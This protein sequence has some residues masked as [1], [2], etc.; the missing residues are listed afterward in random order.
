MHFHDMFL[1]SRLRCG[2]AW[3][4]ELMGLRVGFTAVRPPSVLIMTVLKG[5]CGVKGLGVICI[6]LGG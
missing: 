6:T 4:H 5:V 2:P 3:S 1:N